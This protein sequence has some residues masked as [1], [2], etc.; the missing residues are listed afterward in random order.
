MPGGM[1]LYKL[2][3]RSR[4]ERGLFLC[5]DNVVVEAPSGGSCR[6]SI[7]KNRDRDFVKVVLE[8]SSY[9]RLYVLDTRCCSVQGACVACTRTQGP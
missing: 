1:V 2:P 3:E 6:F 5:W 7:I 4:Y 8:E 9:W